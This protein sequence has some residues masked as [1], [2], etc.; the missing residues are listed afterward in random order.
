MKKIL[1]VGVT[2]MLGSTLYKYFTSKSNIR[3]YG[4]MRS[5]FND[6]IFED[7]EKENIFE[8]IEIQNLENLKNILG[9]IKPDIVLNCVGI[10]K[11]LDES[12]DILKCLKVNSLFPH[13]LSKI[14]TFFNSRL[15]HFSTDCVF[16]G[17][18]GFYK[19]SDIPDAKDIYGLTKRMGEI[20]YGNAVTLR[21]SI[22]G[23]ELSSNKSLVDWFLSQEEQVK[24]FKNAYFSGLP[25]IEIAHILDN[26]V[27]PNTSLCGLYHLSSKRI[28]KFELLSIIKDVYKKNINIVESFDLNIDRSLDSSRFIMQSGYN[29]KDWRSLVAEMYKFK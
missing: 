24:G 26:Y 16:T 25:T 27:I 5:K 11:Q 20:D 22:I 4:T 3:C 1:V 15:I 9:K 13:E 17:E 2:G 28:S 6:K 10:I 14:C 8:N 19:E 29:Q 7:Y 18:K 21:T 23:H 12:K